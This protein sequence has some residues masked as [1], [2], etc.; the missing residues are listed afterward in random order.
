MADSDGIVSAGKGNIEAQSAFAST[1]V[2]DVEKAPLP[3]HSSTDT[4]YRNLYGSAIE[5]PETHA[6][7]D[8]VFAAKA[9]LLNKALLDLGMGRYQW[10]LWLITS[11]GWFLDSV[12]LVFTLFAFVFC[13]YS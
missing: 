2:A 13:C 1:L 4:V 12:S 5:T 8:V 6:G 7:A 9:Q 11:T 3:K 10:F